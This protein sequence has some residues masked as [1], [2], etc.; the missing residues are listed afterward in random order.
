VKHKQCIIIVERRF[1]V[2]R[3][4]A[5]ARK[6]PMQASSNTPRKEG[7]LIVTSLPP[8][9]LFSLLVLLFSRPYLFGSFLIYL[10][11]VSLYWRYRNTATI[12][13]DF[14]LTQEMF[15]NDTIGW[16]LFGA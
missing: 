2:D 1:T 4:I 5:L 8:W 14:L 13:R 10:E 9:S 15:A 11:S 3:S 6:L 16:S 7:F 12:L